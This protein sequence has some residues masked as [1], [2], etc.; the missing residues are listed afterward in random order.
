MEDIY[1]VLSP[2]DGYDRMICKG[3]NIFNVKYFDVDDW[4]QLLPLFVE[5]VISE[6]TFCIS[7]SL[8]DL[9]ILGY[10]FKWETI[11]EI[12]RN[13]RFDLKR[14]IPFLQYILSDMEGIESI[15]DVKHDI[16]I[17]FINPKTNEK[18]EF[19][20]FPIDKEINLFEF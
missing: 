10:K 9:K 18:I 7:K 15:T 20:D 2:L 19:I 17:V 14:G 11:T 1:L 16:C 4:I 3:N 12:V 6:D 13:E 5:N 8:Y